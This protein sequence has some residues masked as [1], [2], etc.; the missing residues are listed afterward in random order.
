MCIVFV[1]HVVLLPTYCVFHSVFLRGPG[2]YGVC[3]GSETF[4][5]SE[6]VYVQS[7]GYPNDYENNSNCTWSVNL[8]V[9]DSVTLKIVDIQ[10]QTSN[11]SCLEDYI[12][13]EYV[14]IFGEVLRK[15]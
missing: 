5:S 9:I 10:L 6:G 11:S 8:T 12:V 2:Q 3:N 15:R 13:L 14:S 4:A 7:A 1:N